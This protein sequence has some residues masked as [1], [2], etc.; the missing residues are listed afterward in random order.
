MQGVLAAVHV[1]QCS[2]L[3]QPREGAA[4]GALAVQGAWE[5]VLQQVTLLR[6]C[7][8]AAALV[9]EMPLQRNPAV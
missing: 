3:H 2:L 4:K 1:Y 8:N 5:A 7:S 6:S 9:R